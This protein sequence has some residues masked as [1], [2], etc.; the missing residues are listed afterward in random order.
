MLDD[1]RI[2]NSRWALIVMA[3]VTFS[4][5]AKDLYYSVPSRQLTI[6]IQGQKSNFYHRISIEIKEWPWHCS[7]EAE[8]LHG[9][10]L[11]SSDNGQISVH[12]FNSLFVS[13]KASQPDTSH[14][15][16][17][18]PYDVTEKWGHKWDGKVRADL[19]PFCQEV[20]KNLLLNS[21]FK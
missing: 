11:I 1:V 7:Y 19:A 5:L 21:G 6:N 14:R 15:S 9:G 17:D 18:I 2:L 10:T 20:R 13:V 3:L 12:D 4:L 8:M 16:V